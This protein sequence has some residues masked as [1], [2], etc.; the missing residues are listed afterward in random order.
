MKKII[1]TLEHWYYWYIRPLRHVPSDIRYGIKNIY[2][3]IK[4]IWKQRD[5]DHSY[6]EQLWLVNFKRKYK[7]YT[8]DKCVQYVGMEKD[9]QGLKICIDI[10]ER[11][12]AGWYTNQWY[13]NPKRE[14]P[15][16][17]IRKAHLELAYKTEERDWK[18]F[19]DIL[20]KYFLRWWD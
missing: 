19:C 12:D 9:I 18:I 2:Y 15:D 20:N 8:S 17:D 16:H 1:D 7:H 14:H 13:D 4:V 5:F 11:R 6:T 10:L 3:Y